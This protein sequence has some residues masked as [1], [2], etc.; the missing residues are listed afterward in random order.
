MNLNCKLLSHNQVS[1]T[2]QKALQRQNLTWITWRVPVG[3]TM[4]IAVHNSS[5]TFTL[6]PSTRSRIR[7]SQPSLIFNAGISRFADMEGATP[8]ATWPPTDCKNCLRLTCQ[9]CPWRVSYARHRKPVG[10]VTVDGIES[11]L[12]KSCNVLVQ[13][14][15]SL[16]SRNKEMVTQIKK[17]SSNCRKISFIIYVWL[18]QRGNKEEGA[19]RKVEKGNA[20]WRNR[21]RKRGR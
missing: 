4:W 12:Q 7:H 19:K 1:Q 14:F 10:I 15:S 20:S 3:V 21:I 18:T 11:N 16:E 8:S 5:T 13:D 9:V 17:K 6:L 2:Y